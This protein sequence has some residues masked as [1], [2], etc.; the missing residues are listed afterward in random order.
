MTFFTVVITTSFTLPRERSECGSVKRPPG[1]GR[2][3]MANDGGTRPTR[4]VCRTGPTGTGK[5]EPVVERIAQLRRQRPDW[6]AR[7]LRQL[8]R[9]EGIVLP[10]ITVHRVL[11]RH[12]LVRPDDRRSPAWQRFERAAPNQLWQM[13][14]KSPK[15]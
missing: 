5:T 15:G 7:K 4:G 3:G 14:F 1:S 2:D 9:A 6:R 10:V 12:G 11:L 8:L 13:D